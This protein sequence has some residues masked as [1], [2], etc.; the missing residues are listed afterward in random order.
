[1][2]RLCIVG[3]RRICAIIYALTQGP[4]QM[5]GEGLLLYHPRGGDVQCRFW[6]LDWLTMPGSAGLKL[7][8]LERYDPG[9]T[10]DQPPS[11]IPTSRT[12][13]SRQDL[14]LSAPHDHSFT[15]FDGAVVVD[16]ETTGCDPKNDRVLRIACLRGSIA[17]FATRGF[18]HLDQF[19]ARLNPGIPIPTGASRLRGINGYQITGNKTFADIA[20]ALREFIGALPLI[21]HNVRFDEAFLS[22]EFNR[23]GQ[24]SLHHNKA[25][26]TMKRLRDHFGYMEDAWYLS[27]AEAAAYFGFKKGVWHY[28][29]ATQNAL[30]A[31]QVAGGLYR[32][33]NRIPPPNSRSQEHVAAAPPPGAEAVV[34]IAMALPPR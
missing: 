26:C 24:N 22:E 28:R 17:D 16:L 11:S 15:E 6:F 18:T 25:Y 7:L 23:A 9:R 1:M 2:T 34:Q 3:Y 14:M 27:L 30:L 10:D 4:K 20:A 13:F 31:L 5:V 21:G 8:R 29:C 12:S 19:T 32:L 33:D